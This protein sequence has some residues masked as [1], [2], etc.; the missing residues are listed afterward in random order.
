MQR[1]LLWSILSSIL[2][3]LIFFGVFYKKVV[4]F[5][6]IRNFF[7]LG[8]IGLMLMLGCFD[9]GSFGFFLFFLVHAWSNVLHYV[10]I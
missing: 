9:R 2:L 4:I 10:I 8:C 7:F 6:H 3:L 5:L 1:T